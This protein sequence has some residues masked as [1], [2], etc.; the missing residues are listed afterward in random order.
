MACAG[1]G[2]MYCEDGRF[3]SFARLA[4]VLDWIDAM[5]LES[6]YLSGLMR[7]GDGQC[8]ANDYSVVNDESPENT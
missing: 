1:A 8:S 6:R 7:D 5:E 3:V 2:W 4:N